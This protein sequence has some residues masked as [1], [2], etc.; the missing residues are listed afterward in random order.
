MFIY[1]KATQS[2]ALFPGRSARLKAICFWGRRMSNLGNA[3]VGLGETISFRHTVPRWCLGPSLKDYTLSNVAIFGWCNLCQ[4]SP[5]EP[6]WIST[7][8]IHFLNK[9]LKHVRTTTFF[10]LGSL[11]VSYTG[12]RVWCWLK[13]GK[14]WADWAGRP[15][16][17]F[18]SQKL[19]KT[20]RNGA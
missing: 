13:V 15:I 4:K 7:T 17:S 8:Q 10:L 6:P 18:S 19:Q 2:E 12:A 11:R 3:T 16:H 20:F 5:V 9:P 14:P 1:S